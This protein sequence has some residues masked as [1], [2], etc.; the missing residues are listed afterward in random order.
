MAFMMMMLIKMLDDIDPEYE[1]IY[2]ADVVSAATTT[3]MPM[4]I[5]IVII[6]LLLLHYYSFYSGHQRC[7]RI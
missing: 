5:I 7:T 4:I 1:Y 2:E 6:I 3:S